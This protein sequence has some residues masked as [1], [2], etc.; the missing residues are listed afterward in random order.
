MSEHFASALSGRSFINPVTNET[1]ISSFQV[2]KHLEGLIQRHIPPDC[3]P[4]FLHEATHHWCFMHTTG[5]ALSLLHQRALSDA[6]AYRGERRFDE[7]LARRLTGAMMR[8]E[9]FIAL[10]RP[11]AEG[12]ALFAEFDLSSHG[13]LPKLCPVLSRVADYFGPG[14]VA[15]FEPEERRDTVTRNLL[16]LILGTTRRRPDVVAR[17]TDVL[18]RPAAPEDG[19]Y[20]PGYLLVKALW[21][22]GMGVDPRL[23]DPELFFAYFI[24]YFHTDLGTIAHLLDEDDDL[25][26]VDRLIEYFVARVV[27]FGHADH[28]AHLDEFLAENKT[29]E[30]FEDWARHGNVRWEVDEA[31]AELGVR[32]LVSLHDETLENATE[33]DL[34]RNV[35]LMF[36]RGVLSLGRHPVTITATDTNRFAVTSGE[37]VVMTG[38]GT[39]DLPTGAAA[40]GQAEISLDAYSGCAAIALST[41]GGQPAYWFSDDASQEWQNSFLNTREALSQAEGESQEFLVLLRDVAKQASGVLYPLEIARD[42]ATEATTVFTHLAVAVLTAAMDHRVPDLDA[43][44]TAVDLLGPSGLAGVFDRIRHIRALAWGGLVMSTGAL[45]DVDTARKLFEEDRDIHGVSDDFDR[46]MDLIRRTGTE[47]LGNPLYTV[48]DGRPLFIL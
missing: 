38:T 36:Q 20:L 22:A 41:A 24:A 4:A 17:R 35:A 27:R 29:H 15:A 12:L 23:G 42:R 31:T 44:A 30:S 7:D 18:V 13:T 3:L 21:S 47:K 33:E 9:A 39:F 5:L 6:A 10:Q 37:T 16:D 43:V 11:L 34:V 26:S 48:R 45:P 14:A 46:T 40:D 28:R 19:G 1:V 32:R 25:R 8:Y 2:G